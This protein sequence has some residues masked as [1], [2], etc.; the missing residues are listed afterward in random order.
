MLPGVL[1]AP[2]TEERPGIWAG[3]RHGGAPEVSGVGQRRGDDASAARATVGLVGE[4]ETPPGPTRSAVSRSVATTPAAAKPPPNRDSSLPGPGHLDIRCCHRRWF[5]SWSA[6]LGF[7]LARLPETGARRAPRHRT[8][9]KAGPEDRANGVRK[10]ALLTEAH[11]LALRAGVPAVMAALHAETLGLELEGALRAGESA[12]AE[13]ALQLLEDLGR[14]SA[15]ST[16]RAYAARGEGLRRAAVGDSVGGAA[17]LTE[18]IDLWERLG[19]QYELASTRLELARLS[20]Q[21]GDSDQANALESAAKEYFD[22]IRVPP[23]RSPA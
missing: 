12:A 6:T 7:I 14:R 1:E 22:R 16:V 3:E 5:E 13:K 10:R 21:S 23:S 2:A 20:R 8:P 4:S 15:Q 17:K 19:W 18:A 11:D 9:W